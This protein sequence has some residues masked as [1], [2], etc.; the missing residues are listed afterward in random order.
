MSIVLFEA[1]NVFISQ[2]KE[3]YGAR[4]FT[5]TSIIL[6]LLFTKSWSTRNTC[7]WRNLAD[8]MTDMNDAEGVS[9]FH[10]ILWNSGIPN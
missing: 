3:I 10:I 8:G 1:R 5:I 2:K 7:S 6:K 4:I 9:I